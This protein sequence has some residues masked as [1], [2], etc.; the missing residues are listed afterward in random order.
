MGGGIGL[1]QL[2]RKRS[3]ILGISKDPKYSG[4]TPSGLEILEDYKL[5]QIMLTM[6]LFLTYQMPMWRNEKAKK[7]NNYETNFQTQI[8]TPTA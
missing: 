7:N 3:Q 8:F 5:K 6:R 2:A 1:R 4:G